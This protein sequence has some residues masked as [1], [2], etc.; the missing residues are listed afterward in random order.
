MKVALVSPYDLSV[1]GGVQQ[2]VLELGDRL[3]ESGHDVVVAGPGDGERWESVGPAISVRGNDSKAPVCL[4]S[5]AVGRVR[6]LVH[7]ADVVHVH[8]PLMPLVAVAASTVNRPKVLT[9]HADPPGWARR[10]YRVAGLPIGAI[11]G[12]ATTTA[13]SEVAA[14]AIPARWGPVRL[15]PNA[16]DT[17]AYRNAGERLA[18]RVAFLGRDDRR[19]G[20]AV[21][22]EAWPR[23]R[24]MIPDAELMV[25]GPTGRRPIE[26][27]TLAGWVSDDEKRRL[28]GSSAVYVAPNLGGESFGVVVAEG[29]AA[30]CAVVASD[31]AAFRA[32]GG[33]AIDYVDPGDVSGLAAVVTELLQNETLRT[34]RGAEAARRAERFDWSVVLE[35]YL[36]AYETARSVV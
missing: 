10:L 16:I 20:L 33:D 30:G 25:M 21:M 15:V 12:R 1:P 3:R 28:L 31:L 4:S 19:K 6:R 32:V 2:Q 14:A 9:F 22:L 23:I 7:D 13:V 26:G 11:I 17:S 35:G 27:V 29:M 24:A 36:S 5:A 8:E 34:A 18:H